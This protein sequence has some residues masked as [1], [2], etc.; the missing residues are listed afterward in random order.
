M[1][2]IKSYLGKKPKSGHVKPYKVPASRDSGACRNLVPVEQKN[3]IA[4]FPQA[5]L[6]PLSK[7]TKPPGS[8]RPFRFPLSIKTGLQGARRNLV[9]DEQKNKIARF[10]EAV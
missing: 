9:R 7:K 2:R 8:C 6:D 5:P 4:R 1:V 3:K 10:L